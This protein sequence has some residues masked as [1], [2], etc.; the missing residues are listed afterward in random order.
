MSSEQSAVVPFSVQA[1][2]LRPPLLGEEKNPLGGISTTGNFCWTAGGDQLNIFGIEETDV[3]E[4]NQL[5]DFG[6]KEILCIEEVSIL[7]LSC[8]V[9]SLRDNTGVC[10]L[11]FLD[12]HRGKTRCVIQLS[13]KLA[14]VSAMCF[15][16]EV[17]KIQSGLVLGTSGGYIVLV[18]ITEV[19]GPSSG[20][21]TKL[22]TSNS[23]DKE[24]NFLPAVV[25]DEAYHQSGRLRFPVMEWGAS[26]WRQ[27]DALPLPEKGVLVTS[28]HHIEKL[29]A[30]AVGYNFGC[31]QLWSLSNLF[32]G[33]GNSLL[34]SSRCDDEEQVLTKRVPIST[35]AYQEL[36][37]HETGHGYLWVGR[38]SLSSPLLKNSHNALVEMYN[39][40][41]RFNEGEY[42]IL[43]SLRKEHKRELD[44]SM[45]FSAEKY[46]QPFSQIISIIN[47]HPRENEFLQEKITQGIN[48]TDLMDFMMEEGRDE[49]TKVSVA[50]GSR[51]LFVWQTF[52]TTST[53]IQKEFKMEIFDFMNQATDSIFLPISL[54]ATG[55]DDIS[56][57]SKLLS[58]WVEPSSVSDFCVK[59]GP[60]EI[61]HSS[62]PL[63]FDIICLS[64]EAV[65]SISYLSDKEKA[66]AAL[67]IVLT[68]A[69]ENEIAFLYSDCKNAG[70]ISSGHDVQQPVDMI[71]ALLDVCSENN[72]IS[73]ICRLVARQ[74]KGSPILG[75]VE[76]WA[77]ETMERYTDDLAHNYYEK[78]LM[79]EGISERSEVLENLNLALMR[80]GNLYNVFAL[81]SRL[82]Q[83]F[84]NSLKES[85]EDEEME[86]GELS[87]AEDLEDKLRSAIKLEDSILMCCQHLELLVWF[88]QK[89]L[90]PVSTT[91]YP[92]EVL[93]KR[94]NQHLKL[95]SDL[96]KQHSSSMESD[97]LEMQ[98]G[99]MSGVDDPPPSLFI[100]HLI[101][102]SI[103]LETR[104]S[105][106]GGRRYPPIDFYCLLMVFLAD[107]PE[108][109][110]S[111]RYVILYV[112]IEL[113]V[114][115]PE[116]KPLV[117]DFA[118]FFMIPPHVVKLILA[119]HLLDTNSDLEKACDYLVDP[120]VES[121]E[122]GGKILKTF[123]CYGAHTEALQYIRSVQPPVSCVDDALTHIKVFL[124]CDLFEDALNYQ[125]SYSKGNLVSENER[126]Y[127]LYYIFDY[128]L[129]EKQVKRLFGMPLDGYELNQIESYLAESTDSTAAELLIIFFMQRGN[130]VSA[131]KHY[132]QV[133]S[134]ST[135]FVQNNFLLSSI[136]QNYKQVIPPI[137]LKIA[138]SSNF[139]YSSSFSSKTPTTFSV[140]QTPD[141][142]Y[143]DFRNHRQVL[144][145]EKRK[146][147][148]QNYTKPTVQATPHKSTTSHTLFAA[149]PSTSKPSTHRNIELRTQELQKQ[150]AS[151]YTPKI[152]QNLQD[153]KKETFSNKLSVK[154]HQ[155]AKQKRDM[156]KDTYAGPSK[157]TKKTYQKRTTQQKKEKVLPG[158]SP[159]PFSQKKPITFL[160]STPLATSST[161]TTYRTSPPSSSSF[162]FGNSSSGIGDPQPKPSP[163]PNTNTVYRPS[164]LTFSSP[165]ANHNASVYKS[166][167]NHHGDNDVSF[168]GGYG[169]S[170][171]AYGDSVPQSPSSS[172]THILKK[173]TP[174]KAM[175]NQVVYA[176]SPYVQPNN[177]GDDSDDK[178]SNE[179]SYK[180]KEKLESSEE[181]Y[182]DY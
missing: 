103:G 79:N 141:T 111:K 31:F 68:Y 63:S 76:N 42:F 46:V 56:P 94:Y 157:K 137:Q 123:Y 147:L 120:A 40:K 27:L 70:L 17:G 13:S 136:M 115:N 131:L 91:T 69:G 176:R 49:R 160:P 140:P 126:Q 121:S 150:M 39:I 24:S 6:E 61:N 7:G 37:Y 59:N 110:V 100:D 158:P 50:I 113:G 58:V 135:D 33:V 71:N 148:V 105:C 44:S 149:P 164:S 109:V 10:E 60:L 53:G 98:E 122:W 182:S 146:P 175:R 77:L 51:I 96:F 168:D 142:I 169:G 153:T 2:E 88:Y 99:G 117:D 25:L 124:S 128:C 18:D 65:Y 144:P 38:S 132:E 52:L 112:L 87:D 30:V 171:T 152:Y 139:G 75:I 151:P 48:K 173:R 177:W 80:L 41:F 12:V 180:G 15:L 55:Q 74:D 172:Y 3:I 161:P 162:L 129:Q 5:W 8:L 83:D 35:F 181:E 104:R 102:Q 67:P 4:R 174:I 154:L 72:L 106:W 179:S 85:L 47:I 62:F 19:R 119:F 97:E 16:G 167:L 81:F 20:V 108:Y 23:T 118:Q 78:E 145:S 9:V 28:L 11:R 107:G 143:L 156:Q 101:E 22:E 92:R 93:A 64:D 116:N 32:S 57:P 133:S 73:T 26:E 138:I 114:I 134:T 29:N 130:F 82:R 125:R 21:I 84:L 90:F 127:L 89:G 43:E 14:P 54:F 170:T 159:S 66:L 155:E 95:R 45:R 163:K 36:P 178:W 1:F 166:Q 34:Y 165:A 86:S